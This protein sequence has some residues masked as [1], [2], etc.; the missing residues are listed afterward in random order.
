MLSNSY[1]VLL[2]WNYRRIVAPFLSTEKHDKK[3]ISRKFATG[4]SI[5]KV[6]RSVACVV[7]RPT[8]KLGKSPRFGG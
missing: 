4:Y 5:Y 2:L 1:E 6:V 7:A 8:G 3:R